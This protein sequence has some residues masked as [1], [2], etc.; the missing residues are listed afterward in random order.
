MTEWITV[1]QTLGVPVA[2]M[3]A[4][5]LGIWRAFYWIAPIVHELAVKHG[6]LVDKLETYLDRTSEMLN[7]QAKHWDEQH[8]NKIAKL[9]DIHAD[10][11]CISSDV[12]EIKERVK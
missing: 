5:G 12:K 7:T 1:A 4:M 2:I 11:R 9:N 3:F 8:I 10:V 6:S